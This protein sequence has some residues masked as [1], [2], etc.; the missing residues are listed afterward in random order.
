MGWVWRLPIEIFLFRILHESSE[1]GGAVLR[2]E[3]FFYPPLVLSV[4]YL[5]VQKISIG[6]LQPFYIWVCFGN[7]KKVATFL[8]LFCFGDKE[9]SHFCLQPFI[10]ELTLLFISL[11]EFLSSWHFTLS[12][13][14]HFF[15]FYH[16]CEIKKRTISIIWYRPMMV[17]NS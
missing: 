13:P 16:C 7:F 15:I 3:N 11:H 1:I 14:Y 17:N 12:L 4:L 6:F 8:C 5:V 2:S 10:F 9:I